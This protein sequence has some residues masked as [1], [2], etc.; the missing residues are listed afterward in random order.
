MDNLWAIGFVIKEDKFYLAYKREGVEV[1][2]VEEDVFN[3]A[4]WRQANTIFKSNLEMMGQGYKSLEEAKE[5]V[6]SYMD[7]HSKLIEIYRAKD[8]IVML[9]PYKPLTEE[10][11]LHIK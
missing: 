4:M 7:A 10:I 11:L 9:K 5:E 3:R 8:G 6:C 1:T 2:E